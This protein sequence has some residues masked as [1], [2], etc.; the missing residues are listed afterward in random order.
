MLQ[1]VLPYLIVACLLMGLIPAAPAAPSLVCR[2]TGQ[3]MEP[4]LAAATQDVPGHRTCCAVTQVVTPEGESR[5]ALAAPGCCDL[6]QPQERADLP[7]AASGPPDLYALIWAP[8]SPTVFSPAVVEVYR[9]A[10]VAGCTP[11]RGPP[12]RT[13]APRAPPPSS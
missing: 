3:Q 6:R 11:P 12:S 4:V 1:R 8:A 2:F 10:P 13:T 9:P 5:Y 7:V